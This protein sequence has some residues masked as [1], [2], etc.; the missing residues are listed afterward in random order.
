MSALSSVLSRYECDYMCYSVEFSPFNPR[1]LGVSTAQNFGVIGNGKQYILTIIIITYLFLT[2]V[3][4]V[5]ISTLYEGPL[6]SI[7]KK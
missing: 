2:L 1:L 4:A 6:R 7:I 5:K 3:V